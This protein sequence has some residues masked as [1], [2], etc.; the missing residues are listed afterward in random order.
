MGVTRAVI[1]MT[2]KGMSPRDIRAAIDAAYARSMRNATP[3]P[4]PPL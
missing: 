4:Y 3:T 1:D 2:A